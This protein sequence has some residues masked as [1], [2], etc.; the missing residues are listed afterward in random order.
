MASISDTLGLFFGPSNNDTLARLMKELVDT[1]FEAATHFRKTEGRDLDGTI[2]YERK[3]DR[4]VDAIH[5]IL[6]NA[7]IMRFDIPDTMR[8]ADELDNVLDGMRKTSMHI[9]IYKSLL[10]APQQDAQQLMICAERMTGR[11]RDLVSMLSEP[12][13][14]LPRVRELATAIDDDESEADRLAADAERR[15]VAEYSPPGAN[16]LEFLA[17][18]KLY[19]Q[20]EEMT[21]HANHCAKLIVS[22]ARKE[23]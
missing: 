4:Q 23:A 17:W 10:K 13:L 5:E 14:S 7:F 22:L 15:L 18:L 16:R 8:L 11:L 9:D 3:G 20:L 12:R 1:M 2:A 19:Q 6:D 21:D